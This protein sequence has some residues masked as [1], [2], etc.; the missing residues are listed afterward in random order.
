MSETEARHPGTSGLDLMD[1]RE[2]VDVLVAAHG[3]VPAIVALAAADTAVAVE[4]A[5]TRLRR[6]G[7]LVFAGSGTPGRL[8]EADASELFPTFGFPIS[9]IAVVRAG[10]DADRSGG[11]AE[12]R[13]ERAAAEIAALALTPDD[14]LV[15][16]ASSGSTPFTTEAARCASARGAFVIAVANVP[17]PA[18]ADHAAVTVILRTRAEPIAG[19]TRMR[20]GL[21][22]RMWLTIFSTAVMAS[23]GL[24]FDNLMVNVVPSLDK[25]RS[26]QVRILQAACGL[27]E[28]ESRDALSAADGHL[29]QAVVATLAG[30]SQR[31][32]AEA[33]AAGGGVRAA[34]ERARAF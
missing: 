6:G 18:L 8:V 19:S 14:V 1:P 13:P 26:R 33:L 20:A 5:A 32:A 27:G 25:L 7:R 11:P 16:V 30:V 28:E 10:G 21:A 15:A 2:L 24:V 31:A 29:A 4:G 12:D 9:R 3:D 22:Q 34:I 23:L 17:E